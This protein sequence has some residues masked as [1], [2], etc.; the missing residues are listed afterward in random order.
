VEP[1][2]IP[3][4]CGFVLVCAY[5]SAIK[6]K[7]L[8]DVRPAEIEVVTRPGTL[9]RAHVRSTTREAARAVPGKTD[10]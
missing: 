2:P 4:G 8:H 10:R 3:L 5:D 7:A 1:H 9:R 6:Q